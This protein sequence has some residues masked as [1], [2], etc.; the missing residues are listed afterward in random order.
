M[1]SREAWLAAMAAVLACKRDATDAPA[2]VREAP[3]ASASAQPA[4]TGAIAGR[5]V[6]LP[7]VGISV[8]SSSDPR[9]PPVLQTQLH[10]RARTCAA[11]VVKR[12]PT[13]HGDITLQIGIDAHGN[14]THVNVE[15][16]F[17]EPAGACLRGSSR[18]IKFAEGT[19]RAVRVIVRFQTT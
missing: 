6:Q 15:S 18:S 7:A 12:D 11:S 14:V 9:D 10:S 3:S 16:S 17:D 1:R 19:A 4:D 5:V 13:L 2:V 8:L